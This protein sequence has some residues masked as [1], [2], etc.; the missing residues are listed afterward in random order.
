LSH[1]LILTCFFQRREH[2]L[3][4]GKNTCEENCQFKEAES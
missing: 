2:G 4:N 1:G 3:N